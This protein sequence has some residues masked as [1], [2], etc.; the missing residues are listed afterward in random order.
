MSDPVLLAETG[1]TYDRASV[2]EWLDRGQRTC[3]LTHQQ[4][5]TRQVSMQRAAMLAHGQQ[6][7]SVIVA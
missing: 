7:C 6:T 4:L 5:V 2:Q 1:M 3:P